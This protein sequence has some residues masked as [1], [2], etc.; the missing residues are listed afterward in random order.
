MGDIR[1][2][3]GRRFDWERSSVSVYGSPVHKVKYNP[4]TGLYLYKRYWRR[5]NGKREFVYEVVEPYG[6]KRAYPSFLEFQEGYGVSISR[7]DPLC[8]EKIEWYLNHGT[9]E[10]YYPSY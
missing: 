2:T 9:N 7:R 10:R 3:G 5:K 8:A 4:D 6:E 1:K